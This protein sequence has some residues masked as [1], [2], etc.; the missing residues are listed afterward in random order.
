MDHI[1]FSLARV[2]EYVAGRDKALSLGQLAGL[3]VMI[4]HIPSK[5]AVTLENVF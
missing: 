1:D 3:K 2:K 4:A 5:E